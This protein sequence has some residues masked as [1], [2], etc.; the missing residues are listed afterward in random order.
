MP[1]SYKIN[2]TTQRVFTQATGF[3]TA[4]EI[5][6]RFEVVRREGF[7]FYSE[8]ID[9][10]SIVKPTLSVAEL[11]KTAM[12][13]RNLKG[14]GKFGSRAVWVANDTIYVLTHMFASLMSGYIRM[15]VFHDPIAAEE[16]LNK[17]SGGK[18][19]SPDCG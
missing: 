5:I 18:S 11:W 1:I 14:E 12:A 8:L 9:A 13:V 19:P 17:K 15:G 10:S 7:L 2:T 4:S 16:W 6:D 3:V